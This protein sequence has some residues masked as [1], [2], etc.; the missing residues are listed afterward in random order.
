MLHPTNS[1]VVELD[2]WF[3]YYLYATFRIRENV[4]T[5]S[6]PFLLFLCFVIFVVLGL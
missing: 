5:A 6:S 1:S 4:L 2:G 3:G